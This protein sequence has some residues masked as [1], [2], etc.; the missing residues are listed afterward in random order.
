MSIQIYHWDA[1]RDGDLNETAMR[2][3]LIAMGYEVYS[4]VYPP[5]T[6][7]PDHTHRVDK[8]DAVLSGQFRMSMLGQSVI[9]KAGD[10]MEVP[11]GV[12]HSAEVVGDEP[13][14]SLDAVKPG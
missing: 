3:K 5:G 10:Y 4:Y 8:I 12:V 11:S 2:E 9:L 6:C 13:V 14:L 1:S 7:F